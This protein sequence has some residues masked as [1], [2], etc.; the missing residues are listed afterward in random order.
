MANACAQYASSTGE[1][2]DEDNR[3]TV[4]SG[5]HSDTIARVFFLPKREGFSGT[6][7][8]AGGARCKTEITD[9]ANSSLH[10]PSHEAVD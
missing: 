8:R 6:S 10:R 5:V 3:N 1:G 2:T 7:R 4:L 9:A